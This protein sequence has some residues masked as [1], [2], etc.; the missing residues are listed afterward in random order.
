MK[1]RIHLMIMITFFCFIACE[2]ENITHTHNYSNWITKTEANC[3]EAKVEKRTCFCGEEE[4]RTIGNPLGH[5]W[6]WINTSDGIQTKTCQRNNCH[7][8]DGIKLI[9]N[10]G[11][12]GPGG[13]KIF[14]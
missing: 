7:D 3:I 11:D 13:G 8:T 1:N 14:Y 12:D 2:N 5:D 6:D 9:L 4:T 10:I